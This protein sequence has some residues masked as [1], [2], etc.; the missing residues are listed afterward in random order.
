[1]EDSNYYQSRRE[2]V[3]TQ[4]PKAHAETTIKEI[5]LERGADIQELKAM[6]LTEAKGADAADDMIADTSSDGAY[7]GPTKTKTHC[8]IEFW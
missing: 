2:A 4:E 6:D 5:I 1:L 8:Y 3:L 7:P